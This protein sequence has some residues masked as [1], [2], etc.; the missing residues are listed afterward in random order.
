MNMATVWTT[1]R[2][3]V[4]SS[5]RWAM[6]GIMVLVLVLATAMQWNTFLSAPS[7]ISWMIVG[8]AELFIAAFALAP[9]LLLSMDARQLCLPKLQQYLFA[10]LC[11]EAFLW[12]VIPSLILSVAEGQLMKIIA[13]EAMGFA[14]GLAFALLPF[15]FAIGTLFAPTVLSVVNI[16]LRFLDTMT[17]AGYWGITLVLIAVAAVCWRRQM[18]ANNPE[19]VNFATPIAVRMRWGNRYGSNNGNAWYTNNEAF[20]HASPLSNYALASLRGSG[21]QNPVRSLRVGLGGSLMPRN[22]QGVLW[23]WGAVMLPFVLL[24]ALLILRFPQQMLDLWHAL[25]FYGLAWLFGFASVLAALMTVSLIQQRWSRAN[26]EL[27]MLALLPGL[28][29]GAA[30]IR[31]LLRASLLPTLCIQCVAVAALICFAVAYHA[32]GMD[33]TLA[34]LTQIDALLFAPAFALAVIGGFAIPAWMGGLI[35]GLSFSLV[36]IGTGIS[37]MVGS[38]YSVNPILSASIFGG[39]VL[40][41]V[42]LCWLGLQGWHGLRRRPHPF[43]LS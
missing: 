27:A 22:W 33:L 38:A 8:Y 40:L 2:H 5:S 18:R 41:L 17:S 14:A 43:L 37:A 13:V 30:L 25:T 11:L 26:A 36:G 19:R 39:W 1:S 34:I 42:F 16:K 15:W 10:A 32:E 21:P 7:W 29:H 3:A 4:V 6:I 23:Q 35:A 28:G 31:R 24:W 12:V 20:P 9:S